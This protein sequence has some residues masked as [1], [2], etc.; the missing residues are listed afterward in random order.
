[1]PASRFTYLEAVEN[2]IEKCVERVRELALEHCP[3]IEQPLNHWIASALR[4]MITVERNSSG[5][6]NDKIDATAKN[7]YPLINENILKIWD[8]VYLECANAKGKG[9]FSR[10]LLLHQKHF[11]EVKQSQFT[12][13]SNAMRAVFKQVILDLPKFFMKGTN[14]ASKQKKAEFR[15]LLDNYSLTATTDTKKQAREQTQ[16]ILQQ[17]RQEWTQGV[18][19]EE[20]EVKIKVEAKV[21]SIDD[22]FEARK[23][24]SKGEEDDDMYISD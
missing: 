7:T 13:G 9:H 10:N 20:V 1:M 21:P 5:V 16:M 3:Q 12:A 6:Y 23:E 24:K 15:T 22:L 11:E 19:I 18:E 14:K 17:L 8:P 2:A 4:T